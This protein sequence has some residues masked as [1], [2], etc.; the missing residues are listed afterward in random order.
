M[1]HDSQIEIFVFLLLE[2]LGFHPHVTR[3]MSEGGGIKTANAC[4]PG[5]LRTNPSK[6]RHCCRN[7]FLCSKATKGFLPSCSDRSP[8][9]RPGG[10]DRRV[11]AGVR[12]KSR[13]ARPCRRV[14]AAARCAGGE[15]SCP[16]GDRGPRVS[17]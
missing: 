16:P 17:S 3:M 12:T 15:I 9:D 10:G 1:G 6:R 11:R 5:V 13:N 8:V 2:I 14:F 7:A 4:E